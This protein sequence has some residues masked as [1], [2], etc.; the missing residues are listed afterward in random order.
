MDEQRVEMMIANNE[1]IPVVFLNAVNYT[2]SAHDRE[3]S[4]GLTKSVNRLGVYLGL[5]A[6]RDMLR[7]SNGYFFFVLRKSGIKTNGQSEWN[8]LEERSSDGVTGRK[9]GVEP[10]HS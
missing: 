8:T 1:K 10:A 3:A 4:K 2:S 7:L 6:I 5:L 9:G